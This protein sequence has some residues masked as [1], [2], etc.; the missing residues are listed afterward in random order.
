MALANP[1][2]VEVTRGSVVES[3]HRGAAAVIDLAR[4]QTAAWGDVDAVVFPRSAVKPL[5]ALPLVESGRPRGS[6][7]PTGNLLSHAHHTA[8]SRSMSLL[9]ASGLRGWRCQKRT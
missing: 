7:S 1:V 3:R 5:Q 9:R 2:L 8:A 6:A 4:P